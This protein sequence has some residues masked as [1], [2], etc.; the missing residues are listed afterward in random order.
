MKD[1]RILSKSRIT[2]DNKMVR[3]EFG[4]KMEK[5]NQKLEEVVQEPL[6]GELKVPPVSEAVRE[7]VNQYWERESQLQGYYNETNLSI[8]RILSQI[9]VLPLTWWKGYSE[10]EYQLLQVVYSAS[11]ILGFKMIR[12]FP[13][14][15]RVFV[16][17]YH[18]VQQLT[19]KL[20][21]FIITFL[22]PYYSPQY[23]NKIQ[24][25]HRILGLTEDC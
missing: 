10:D 13:H 25:F 9:Q 23:L 11:K 20:L 18:N 7:K 16:A 14:I 1:M 2:G 3:L 6:K 8:F 17:L 24:R 21:S 4:P 19:E 5:S 12:S 15:I 22:K